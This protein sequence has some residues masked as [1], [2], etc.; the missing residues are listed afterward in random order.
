MLHNITILLYFSFSIGI[1]SAQTEIGNAAFYADKFDGR[2][3]AS[4]AIFKQ[5]KL[6]A[7]HRTLAFGSK[8]R[9]TNLDN[10]KTVD[11]I[12]NDRGP[13][14]KDRIIDVSKSAAY[15]LDF[16]KEG[17]AKV[18]VEVLDISK[19]VKFKNDTQITNKQVLVNPNKQN[20][21]IAENTANKAFDL[22]YYE[23][24]T[25]RVLPAGFGIQIAS[26]KE[27]INLIKRCEDIKNETNKNILVKIGE[28][29]G[30]KVYR[31]IVGPFSTREY[32]NIVHEKL[33]HQYTGSFVITF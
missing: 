31:I 28:N 14:V 27:V 22:E 11:V 1:L 17:V 18:K 16:I 24:A 4:G 3:T 23:V 2:R 25:K 20:L 32:A 30:Q 26:Y 5:N 7:A 15:K 8:V 33:K 13:F 19:G 9:V 29:K 21:T 10:N 12:I 6:T